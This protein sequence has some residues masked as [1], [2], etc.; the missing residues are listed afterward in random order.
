MK[1]TE[2]KTYEKAAELFS[3]DQIWDIFDGN[4]K[5]FNIAHE[6]IDRHMG[7]GTAIQIKFS[8]GHSEQYSFDEI[9]HLSSQFAHALDDENIKFGDRIAHYVGPVSGVLC[10]PFRYIKTRG[11]RCPLFYPCSDL[12]RYSTE[13]KVPDRKF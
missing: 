5:Y 1:I 7:K 13:L 2:Y 6:C 12:R 3:W 4:R 10:K 11:H 8:D 9:S